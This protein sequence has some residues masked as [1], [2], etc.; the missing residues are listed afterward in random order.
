MNDLRTNHIEK[1]GADLWLRFIAGD[2]NAYASLYKDHVESMILYGLK[3]KPDKNEVQD[4][5]QDLFV[6]LW[7][8][9]QN[10]KPV[11]LV[12]MYLLKALR[13]KLI[14]K[15]K[16]RISSLNDDLGELDDTIL[17]QPIEFF[18]LENEDRVYKLEKIRK[19]IQLLP[20]RQQEV[21]NLRFYKGF[22]TEQV[23]EIMSINY[24]SASN[25]LHKAVQFLRR[26]MQFIAFCGL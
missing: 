21:I 26:C 15:E 10:L 12:S 17:E 11:Q 14:K 6:E 2:F 19:A 16:I 18:I 8:S 7:H 24:Q 20:K 9:K 3:I 25:L 4:A 5:I 23:A 1:Q 13:Y 22:S